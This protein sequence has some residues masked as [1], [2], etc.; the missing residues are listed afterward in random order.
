MIHVYLYSVLLEHAR[1]IY[2][3]V[4]PG[5]TEYNYPILYFVHFSSIFLKPDIIFHKS[6]KDILNS[7][8][9]TGD[10]ILF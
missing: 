10:F 7:K 5:N 9:W 6:V 1:F 3:V 8:D 2:I 4:S